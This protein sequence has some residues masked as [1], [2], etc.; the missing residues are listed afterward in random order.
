M[1]ENELSIKD[2]CDIF[3]K[4]YVINDDNTVD[5]NWIVQ[6]HH[7]GLKKIPIQF[8]KVYLNFS[9]ADNKLINLNGCPEYVGGIFDCSD[10]H[11][12]SLEG[13]PKKV[14]IHYYCDNN[15]LLSLTGFPTDLGNGVVSINLLSCERNPIYEEYVKFNNHVDYFRYLKIKHLLNDE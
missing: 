4:K 13:G 8:G 1:I 15:N 9:C 12:I 11:L 6:I 14:D 10:N 7:M 3:L 5:V 2:W